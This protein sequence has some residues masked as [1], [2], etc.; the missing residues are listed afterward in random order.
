[1]CLVWLGICFG[2]ANTCGNVWSNGTG[3]N[4]ETNK[5]HDDDCVEKEF[6]LA[7]VKF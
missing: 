5:E 3:Q 2:I 6:Q 7:R 4:R 1:M